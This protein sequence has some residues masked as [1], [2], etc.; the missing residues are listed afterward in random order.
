MIGRRAIPV[1]SF[2]TRSVIAVPASRRFRARWGNP[3]SEAAG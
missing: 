1:A 3:R 2:L